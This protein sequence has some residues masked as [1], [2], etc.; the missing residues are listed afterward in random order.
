MQKSDRSGTISRPSEWRSEPSFRA[1]SARQYLAIPENRPSRQSTV[2][3]VPTRM[4]VVSRRQAPEREVSSIFPGDW[5]EAPPW[6]SQ[7]TV[8]T[9]MMAVLRSARSTPIA[10]HPYQQVHRQKTGGLHSGKSTKRLSRTPRGRSRGRAGPRKIESDA[11][12]SIAL[13]R[14][15]AIS[16]DR[17]SRLAQC[18]KAGWKYARQPAS[19]LYP[20]SD[21]PRC[22]NSL[23]CAESESLRCERSSPA[24]LVRELKTQRDCEMYGSA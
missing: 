10:L 13:V 14:Y 3:F 20:P 21:C 4:G 15:D 9:A 1:P 18:V 6:S 12:V 2:N 22:L 11:T 5:R 16:I 17:A 24:T 8:A 7:T 23:C 19:L